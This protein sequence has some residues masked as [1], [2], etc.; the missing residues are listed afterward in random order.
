M[1][2]IHICDNFLNMLGEFRQ[3]PLYINRNRLMHTSLNDYARKQISGVESLSFIK[4]LTKCESDLVDYVMTHYED[5]LPYFTTS[6]GE[7]KVSREVCVLLYNILK[8]RGD[9]RTEEF[10]KILCCMSACTYTNKV[11]QIKCGMGTSEHSLK[12]NITIDRLWMDWRG[13][14]LYFEKPFLYLQEEDGY[15][16]YYYEK[17]LQNLIVLSM[18]FDGLDYASAE[19]KV[20]NTTSEFMFKGISKEIENE[21]VKWALSGGV[22]T[23]DGA[24]AGQYWEYQKRMY[25]SD[26]AYN[27]FSMYTNQIQPILMCMMGKFLKMLWLQLRDIPESDACISYISPVRVGLKVANHLYIE[28]VLGSLAGAFKRLESQTLDKL[29]FEL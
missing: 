16:S 1:S 9:K 29:I 27:A 19:H 21:L 26:S 28:D 15:R 3:K 17:P 10:Y 20:Y 13:C 11:R 4:N 8:S 22:K 2:D 14:L 5:L 7:C 18:I 12:N 24:Y 23:L 6:S 25:K